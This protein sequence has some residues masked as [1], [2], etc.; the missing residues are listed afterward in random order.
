MKDDGDIFE[1]LHSGEL[2]ENDDL[3]V[4]GSSRERSWAV[5][6]T[7]FMIGKRNHRKHFYRK[8]MNTKFFLSFHTCS[9]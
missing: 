2:L 3:G 9:I 4:G 7:S 1:S 6:S 5:L 8:R